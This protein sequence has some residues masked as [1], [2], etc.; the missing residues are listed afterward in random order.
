MGEGIQVGDVAPAFRLPV[1][2]GGE[3]GLSDYRG[4]KNVVV[5]FTKGMGCPFCRQQMSQLAR[6]YSR[7]QELGAEMLQVTV[8]PPSRGEVYAKKFSLPFPYLCDP[9]YRVRRLYGV[10]RRRRGP[11]YYVRTF[12]GGSK[13]SEVH[14][15]PTEF[16]PPTPDF[17]QIGRV[18]ADDDIGFFIVDRDGKIRYALSGTYLEGDRPRPIPSNDE[19][20]RELEKL[21]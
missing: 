17:P 20:A 2:Q 21:Q 6:G 4:D 18:L 7:F 1:A 13:M 8:T 15:A 10:E 5:W 14:G 11:V 3:V 12:L 16:G 9:D 19:I